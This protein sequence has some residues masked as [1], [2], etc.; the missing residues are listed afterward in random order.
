MIKRIFSKRSGFTLVEIL[1][2]FAIFTVMMA[3]IMQVLQLSVAARRQ[4]T[5][6]T[7]ERAEQEEQLILGKNYE[8]DKDADETG[9]VGLNFGED[10]KYEIN[11]QIKGTDEDNPAEG[12]NYFIGDV[13]YNA[14]APEGDKKKKES[15][16]G[17]QASRY[18]TRI[19]GTAD[20]GDITV[21]VSNNGGGK[22][23]FTLKANSAGVVSEMRKYSQIRLY[24]FDDTKIYSDVSEYVDGYIYNPD[25]AVKPEDIKSYKK[26]SVPAV[27]KEVGLVGG[28]QITNRISRDD[29]QKE[30]LLQGLGNSVRISYY[31]GSYFGGTGITFYVQFDGDPHISASSFGE[32]GVKNGSEVKYTKLKFK[33][34]KGNVIST[35]ENIYGGREFEVDDKPFT[36]SVWT[37]GK[38]SDDKNPS[39]NVKRVNS[40]STPSPS[41]SPTPEAPAEGGEAS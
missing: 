27:V 12:L 23:T 34:D 2:A 32:N 19:T 18:D 9:K 35:E 22:Y 11:Y 14:S 4:N 16:T 13:D 5:E 17:S 33:D 6:M 28:N 41:P 26:C 30:I 1:V 38:D 10:S 40:T 8:Y 37:A 24:F 25:V 31:G 21:S 15:E 20:L 7:K 29:S 39:R 3:M 36:G